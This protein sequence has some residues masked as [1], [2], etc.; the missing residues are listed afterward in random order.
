MT[1]L[2]INSIFYNFFQFKK[3]KSENLK[4]SII[5]TLSDLEFET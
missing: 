5:K 3:K 1:W 4:I 2:S